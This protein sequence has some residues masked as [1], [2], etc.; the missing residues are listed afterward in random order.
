M[1]SPH[2]YSFAIHPDVLSGHSYMFE[3][4]NPPQFDLCCFS[5]SFYYTEFSFRDLPPMLDTLKN[6]ALKELQLAGFQVKDA[7][8]LTLADY[9]G[10]ADHIC[11]PS[12]MFKMPGPR[13]IGVVMI[14]QKDDT[15]YDS[16]LVR[17]EKVPVKNMIHFFHEKIT[18]H[19]LTQ[20]YGVMYNEKHFIEYIGGSGKYRIAT[21]LFDQ[22]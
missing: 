15:M 17:K 13:Q 9:N 19:E 5:L 10:S 21:L 18:R 3:S 8:Y 2:T 14:F 12:T 4:Y 20:G 6:Y 1:S 16:G 22:K 7:G 11:P